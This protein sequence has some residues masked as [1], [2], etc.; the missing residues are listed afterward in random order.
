MGDCTA[1]DQECCEGIRS[2]A[3]HVGGD[4]VTGKVVTALTRGVVVGG[5]SEFRNCSEVDWTLIKNQPQQDR[6]SLD[7]LGRC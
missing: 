3:W 7:P 1:D 6:E 2:G 4:D 5:C